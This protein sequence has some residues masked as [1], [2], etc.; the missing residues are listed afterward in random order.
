LFQALK[1]KILITDINN[2]YLDNNTKEEVNLFIQ[3]MIFIYYNLKS[4]IYFHWQLQL[5]L[6]QISSCTIEFTACDFF[7]LNT[8]LITSVSWPYDHT[9]I[10]RTIKTFQKYY[11]P[12]LKTNLLHPVCTTQLVYFQYVLFIGNC[13]W[14]DISRNFTTI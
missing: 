1:S 10:Y 2:R 11:V 6:N 7:T 9:T 5:F 4:C 8:H 13:S 14:D 12:I 3:I